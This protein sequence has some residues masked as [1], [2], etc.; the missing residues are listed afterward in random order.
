MSGL[1]DHLR[2]LQPGFSEKDYGYSGFLQFV[3][4]ADAKGVIGMNWDDE[5]EDYV[6][7]AT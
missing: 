1:K 6:L 2:K 4:A 7:S 5:A 3:K